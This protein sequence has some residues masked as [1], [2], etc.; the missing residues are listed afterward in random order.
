[1]AIFDRQYIEEVYKSKYAEFL[2]DDE[3]EDKD[4]DDDSSDDDEK[5]D[6]EDKN[7]DDEESESK[8]KESDKKSDSKQQPTVK[9]S[10]PDHLNREDIRKVL[11]VIHVFLNDFPKLKKCCDFIDLSDKENIN[12]DGERE[13]AYDA[14]YNGKPTA[15]LKLVDGD[16]YSGYPD[17]KDNS[18]EYEKD[19]ASF[20]KAVNKKLEEKK[21]PAKLSTGKD[22]DD[23]A[24]SFGVKSTKMK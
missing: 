19:C 24:I 20:I 5:D 22:R 23:E 10:T 18:E 9:P 7:D 6:E 2:D 12:D 3:D 11:D 14:Y 17:Y 16:A 8:E 13:S 4:E 21:I 15:F 1:M